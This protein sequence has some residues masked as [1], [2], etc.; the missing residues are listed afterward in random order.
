MPGSGSIICLAAYMRLIFKC[1]DF[2]C[3]T[4]VSFRGWK[5]DCDMFWIR[6][7]NCKSLDSLDL[8]R[9]AAVNYK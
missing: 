2:S 9:T 1:Q 8:P 3:V 6:Q 7:P 5:V 4:R